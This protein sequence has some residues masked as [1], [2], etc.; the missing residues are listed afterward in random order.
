MT[1]AAAAAIP[2]WIVARISTG[3]MDVEKMA[4]AA[5]L[6]FKFMRLQALKIVMRK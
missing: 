5:A 4:D 3:M 6:V 1:H 2:I